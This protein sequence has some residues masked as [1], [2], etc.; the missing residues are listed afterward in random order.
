M[1]AALE[2]RP[3]NEVFAGSAP[4]RSRVRRVLVVGADPRGQQRLRADRELRAILEAAD[5]GHLRVTSCPAAAVTDLRRLLDDDPTDL[6]H[7]ACHGDGSN[8]IFE[9]AAGQEQPVPAA[10]VARTLAAYHRHGGV[11]LHGLVLG[12][13]HGDQVVD[14]FRGLTPEGVAHTG[15]LDDDCAVVFAHHLYRDLRTAPGLASAALLAARHTV[16]EDDL[17]QSLEDGLVVWPAPVNRSD[18]V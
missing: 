13:C 2:R 16:L 14:L 15:V 3:A 1:A 17:C 5:L 12:S 9:D 7:L 18:S 10:E 11:R 8:L 6:L 4:S